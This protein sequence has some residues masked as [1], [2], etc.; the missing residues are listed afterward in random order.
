MRFRNVEEDR[1]C[2]SLYEGISGKDNDIEE[3]V[4]FCAKEALI[5]PR[6]LPVRQEESA[7][8]YTNISVFGSWEKMTSPYD[9]QPGLHSLLLVDESGEKT[10]LQASIALERNYTREEF[11][12]RLSNK[13]ELGFDGW[14]KNNLHFYRAKTITYTGFTSIE[15][16][17][18][19]SS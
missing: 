2:L 3:A 6:Y 19:T 8:L 5:D 18:F 16:D 14:K 7:D 17:S 1:G 15:S 13:A 9:F 10:L 4:Q 11:L 12:A